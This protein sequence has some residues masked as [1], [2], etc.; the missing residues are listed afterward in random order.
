MRDFAKNADHRGRHIPA[1]LS[2]T[3]KSSYHFVFALNLYLFNE[4]KKTETI[5]TD[6][7][8]YIDNCLFDYNVLLHQSHV[9][10]LK[11]NLNLSFNGSNWWWGTLCPFLAKLSLVR[12]L[13]AAK[14]CDVTNNCCCFFLLPWLTCNY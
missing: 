13:Y 14:C 10:L 3:Q 8:L 1:N 9:I 11:I 7:F 6:H 2:E 5:Q 12:S 4:R